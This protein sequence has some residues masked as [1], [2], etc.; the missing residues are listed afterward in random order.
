MFSS[1][2][3]VEKQGIKYFIACAAGIPSVDYGTGLNSSLGQA[4]VYIT[5]YRLAYEIGNR[6]INK[7]IR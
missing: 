1:N 7:Y 3:K 5:E 4:G 2:P 6:L